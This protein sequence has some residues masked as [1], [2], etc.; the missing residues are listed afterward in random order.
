MLNR[1]MSDELAGR[2][3]NRERLMVPLKIQGTLKEPEVIAQKGQTQNVL[4][5][6]FMDDI[7]HKLRSF[8]YLDQQLPQKLSI[9]NKTRFL[10]VPTAPTASITKKAGFFESFFGR[11]R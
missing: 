11:R 8:Y 3:S 1:R 9:P 10:E 6:A 5:K 2:L 7:T 4:N